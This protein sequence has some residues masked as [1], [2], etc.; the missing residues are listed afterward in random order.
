MVVISAKVPSTAM[1]DSSM[2]TEKV[3]SSVTVNSASWGRLSF[4]DEATR[5]VDAPESSRKRC[6]APSRT[7]SMRGSPV[8]RMLG[9]R[10]TVM[11]ATV[12][13]LQR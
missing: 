3:E 5:F 8:L 11:S 7:T 4:R 12:L 6:F 1:P 9:A 2:N 10:S 13:S